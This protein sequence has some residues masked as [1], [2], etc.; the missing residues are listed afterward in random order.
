MLSASA[1]SGNPFVEQPVQSK[2]TNKASFVSKV[3]SKA[4]PLR[5]LDEEEQE[6]DLSPYSIKYV[7]CQFVKAYDDEMAENEEAGTVLMTNRF[8]IFRLCPSS[9][10]AY[11]YGEYLIDMETYLESAVQYQ[12]EQQ[13]NM[14]GY[15]EE[16]C[17]NDDANRRLRRLEDDLKVDCDTCVSECEDI[18]NMEENGYMDASNFIECQQVGEDDDGTQYFAGA[19][20]G[21]D[22]EKI[23]IG[24]FNDEQ[25][26]TPD[27][28]ASLSNYLE[29]AELNYDILKAIYNQ[30]ASI[31]CIQEDWE[32][33]EDDDGN[34]NQNQDEE[35]EVEINE[36]CRE[37]YDGAAKCESK[38]GFQNGADNYEA[39]ENQVAQEDLVCSFIKTLSSGAYDQSGEIVLKSNVSSEEGETA[40]TGGQKFALAVFVLG[41]VGF[42]VYAAQLHSQLTSGGA[43][44]MGNQGGAMA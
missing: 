11:N 3:M 5:R 38:H 44:G 6:I 43:S 28:S 17:A 25:C 2:K 42:T 40:T 8:V 31:S 37:L 32:V 33:P 23:T 9:S 21:S 13:E 24:I 14:C 35:E 12:Q 19:R 26:S 34:G 7:K 18:E 30:E 36:M 39:Y 29:G 15:C 10:C 41:T 20:C 22:G 27:S 1:V 16:V 4:H